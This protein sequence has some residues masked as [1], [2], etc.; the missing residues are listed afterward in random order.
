MKKFRR[1]YT[2][3]CTSNEAEV[4]ICLIA[5]C[6]FHCLF[7]VFSVIFL[8][9]SG[10]FWGVDCGGKIIFVDDLKFFLKHEICKQWI[11]SRGHV[12]KYL[13]L[14]RFLSW[15]CLSMQSLQWTF[16]I[17]QVVLMWRV[18]EWQVYLYWVKR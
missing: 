10:Y 2:F 6:V 13:V 18:L 17:G 12:S 8:L 4:G 1:W 16:V 11:Y 15:K 9:F 5:S 14:D 3:G 7:I